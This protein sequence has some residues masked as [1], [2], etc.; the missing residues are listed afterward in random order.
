MDAKSSNLALCEFN[1]TLACD[2][3]SEASCPVVLTTRPLVPADQAPPVSGASSLTTKTPQPASAPAPPAASTTPLLEESALM[4]VEP[5]LEYPTPR[6]PTAARTR[7]QSLSV[8]PVPAPEPSNTNNNT[9][10][11]NNYSHNNHQ[12]RLSSAVATSFTAS[13]NQPISD[14]GIIVRRR[15]SS[16]SI[17]PAA[18]P[19]YC[20]KGN[21][22]QPVI[23][24]N[25]ECYT[26]DDDDVISGDSL[27]R[28][29]PVQLI[30]REISADSFATFL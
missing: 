12:R 9:N 11:N 5:K 27:M 21:N 17:A 18:P 20:N 15:N 2:N 14:D 22:M 26:D 16:N 23:D 8:A 28:P 30:L 6:P 19:S 25:E 29:G 1:P 10:H 24:V 4:E 3:H 7:A 13:A